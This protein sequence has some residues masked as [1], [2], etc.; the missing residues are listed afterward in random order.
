MT[1]TDTRLQTFLEGPASKLPSRLLYAKVWGSHSHATEL[2]A[3]DVDYLAVFQRPTCEVLSLDAPAQTIDGT[4]PDFQAHEIAKLGGLLLKG[5][6][7]IVEMLYTEHM[8]L[9]T[10]AWDALREMRDTFLNQATLRQYLGYCEGQLHRLKGGT[11]LHTQ[12]GAYNTKW[13]YH[14][15]RIALDA[16]RIAHGDPPLVMKDGEELRLL[17]RIRA[18]E[19]SPDEIESQFVEVKRR[20]D[21]SSHALREKPDQARL[22]EWLW[23]R[24]LEY[25]E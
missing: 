22:D 12:G 7:G 17:M 19:F 21:S 16:E 8:Q 23:Q 15:I 9:T 4:K 11:R 25:L 20:I 1:T 5:N 13:A 18:G 14:L 24:R 2:P 10:P 3:S 6:P